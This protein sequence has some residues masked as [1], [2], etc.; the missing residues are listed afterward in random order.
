MASFLLGWGV[1]GQVNVYSSGSYERS[2]YYAGYA[3][4]DFKW[5]SKLTLNLGLRY[6]LYRPTVDKWNHLA[7]VDMKLPNPALG[8]F[9]GTMV[10]AT[11]ERRTGVDQFNNGWAPRF[12]LAYSL[13]PTTVLRAG[14]GLL[15]LLRD[16]GSTVPFFI[17]AGSDT[18]QFRREAAERGAQLST[19]DMLEL[20]DAVANSLGGQRKSLPRASNIGAG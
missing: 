20:V 8:G 4:D 11:P 7:W 9:P 10:F 5:T 13:T 14:Y 19:N 17:F 6:D 3:Q 2:G 15:K 1:F 18:P 12:G 16:G